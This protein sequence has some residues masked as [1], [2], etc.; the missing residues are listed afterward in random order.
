MAKIPDI[1]L[2]IMRI[3]EKNNK[4]KIDKKPRRF[5]SGKNNRVYDINGKYVLKIEG[6][7]DF[8]QGILKHQPVLL[9]KLLIAGAQVPQVLDQGT[10][11][12]KGYML[13]NKLLGRNLG[14]YWHKFTRKEKD[15][16]FH[17]IAIELKIYH[18]FKFSNYAIS[19]NL[20]NF[21]PSF[22]RAV[23]L[24]SN[25]DQIQEDL[26]D[27]PTQEMFL[28]I[29]NFWINNKHLIEE[30][31]TA[32]LVHNDAYLQNFLFQK[33]RLTGLVDHDWLCQAP[34][35]YELWKILNYFHTPRFYVAPQLVNNYQKP[36]KLEL[37]L[38]K[39]YYPEIF[40]VDR[41]LD[42]FRLFY[43]RSFLF[44]LKEYQQGNSQDIYLKKMKYKFR[45]F[46]Q[47]DRLKNFT[48]I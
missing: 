27:K 17:Q 40:S 46:Y 15:Q 10:L 9:E 3:I 39:K 4:I 14:L 11:E 34:P 38:L 48:N 5:A 29:K 20:G 13:M 2:R 25:F 22:R 43:I 31:N 26:L 23:W 42:R 35:D 21:S 19:I 7:F 16:L 8:C 6:E 24:T 28:A 36:L 33:N 32:V 41:L 30:N 1:D 47:T 12:G 44:M 45:D 18:S 37:E